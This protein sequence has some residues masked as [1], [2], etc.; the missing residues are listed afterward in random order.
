MLIFILKVSSVRE[1][2][3]KI[4]LFQTTA[5]AR[6]GEAQTRNQDSSGFSQGWQ[7]PRH[8]GHL[9]SQAASRFGSGTAKTQF[10]TH[11][12]YWCCYLLCDSAG[13]NKTLS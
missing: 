1:K 5:I 7:G 3:R 6:L 4:F 10:G 11:T 2:E 13:P 8:L 12:G 9:F